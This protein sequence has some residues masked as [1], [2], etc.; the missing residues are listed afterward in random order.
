M[1]WQTNRQKAGGPSPARNKR[2]S[3]THPSTP[4]AG[5][6]AGMWLLL[7]CLLPILC[8]MSLWGLRVHSSLPQLSGSLSTNYLT[9]VRDSVVFCGSCHL[10][11]LVLR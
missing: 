3:L 9:E 10:G 1:G 11:S 4:T 8:Y 6:T 5:P 2:V 7:L